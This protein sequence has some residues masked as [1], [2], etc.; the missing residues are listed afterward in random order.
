MLIECEFTNATDFVRERVTLL[1]GMRLLIDHH[2]LLYAVSWDEAKHQPFT[3]LARLHRAMHDSEFRIHL[4]REGHFITLARCLGARWTIWFIGV[5][6]RP[7]NA[8]QSHL[9]RI[10]RVMRRR[11][12]QRRLVGDRVFSK[13]VAARDVLVAGRL[14]SNRDVVELILFQYV[15]WP[16]RTGSALHSRPLRWVKPERDG[17]I[18]A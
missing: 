11:T 9:L 5:D 16:K 2:G 6:W 10:Q 18:F 7:R 1:T 13:A 4:D 15:L 14:S 3:S 17:Q 8:L 12:M